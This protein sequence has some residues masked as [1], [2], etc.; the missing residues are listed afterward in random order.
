MLDQLIP[1]PRLLELD[2]VDLAT[3]PARAWQLVRHENLATSPLIHALFALRELP[4]RLRGDHTKLT[5]RIDDLESSRE[6]PGFQILA[7]DPL[8]EFVVGAIGKVWQAEIP[9]VHV[10]DA[11]QYAEFSDAGFVKVAWA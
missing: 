7:E 9:F 8:H 4:R 5:L 1:T 10:D 11:R 3:S 6:K 2:G